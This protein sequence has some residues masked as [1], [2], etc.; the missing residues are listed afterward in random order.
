MKFKKGQIVQ[1]RKD[2]EDISTD[3]TPSMI[4]QAGKYYRIINICTVA[5]ELEIYLDIPEL[6]S[7]YWTFNSISFIFKITRDEDI[8]VY[9]IFAPSYLIFSSFSFNENVLSDTPIVK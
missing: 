4:A 8:I 9:E 2:I 7:S 1:I 3:L 5:G 6:D